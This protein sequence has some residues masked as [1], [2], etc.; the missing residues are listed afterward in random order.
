MAYFKKE[1]I[2]LNGLQRRGHVA[3]ALLETFLNDMWIASFEHA[4]MYV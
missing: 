2:W 3:I 1:K 4:G